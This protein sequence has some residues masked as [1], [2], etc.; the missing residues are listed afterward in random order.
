M[1]KTCDHPKE[2]GFAASAWSHDAEKLS[3]VDLER[4]VFQ[5]GDDLRRVWV[6]FSH[7]GKFNVQQAIAIS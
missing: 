3:L 2:C 6:D 4:N 5:S 7:V 1:V